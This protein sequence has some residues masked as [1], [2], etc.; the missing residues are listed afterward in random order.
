MVQALWLAAVLLVQ[1]ATSTQNP[2][3]KVSGTVVR[4]DNQDP[5]RVPNNDRILLRGTGSTAIIDIGAGGAFEFDNV[6]PGAY[7]I[8]V[9]PMVTMQPLPVV[10]TDRDVSG[11]R[12]LIP[13]VVVVRGTVIVEGSGPHPRF[14][15]AFARTDGPAAAA[16]PVNVT[17]GATFTAQLHSGQYRITTSGLPSGYSLKSMT[18][19]TADTLAQPLKIAAGDSEP[20][21]VTLGVSSPPPWVKVS[22]RVIAGQTNAPGTSVTMSGAVAGD[23]LNAALSPNG[24]FEFSKVLPG[25]YTALVLPATALSASAALTVGTADVTNFEIRPPVP[26]EVKGRIVI[27]RNV[28]MPRVVFSLAP[29]GGGAIPATGAANLPANPQQDGSFTIALPEGER[30]ITVVPGAIPAGYSLASFTYATTDLLK[31]PLRVVKT[32]SAELAVTFDATGVT[33]VNVSGRVAGL[34]TTQGVRVVLMS[35]VLGSV[36]APVNADGSFAFARVIPGSYLARLSLSGISAGSSITVGNRDVTDAIITYPREFVVTGHTI[37][38]GGAAG[39]S[40]QVVLEAKPGAGRSTTSNIVN[41][42]VIMLN[43]KDGEYNVSAKSIPS[44]YQLKSIMYGTTDLQ[45]A[46]LKIDGPVTW[47]I[48][49]RLVPSPPAA[50]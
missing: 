26:K 38:E 11:V 17:I 23:V 3:F 27:K 4:E 12:V 2:G 42:G 5:D 15:M 30:Q 13:D 34:L 6:R 24:S 14:Q 35:P 43:V 37:V 18:L 10:V 9:G 49:V 44:G 8:V 1:G 21:A 39:A 46:P 7:Q 40:P 28:P 32:D 41:G 25:S 47:E 16:A 22:G 20:I 45:E 31:N 29:V 50:K 48:I 19:G 33:P 36:E